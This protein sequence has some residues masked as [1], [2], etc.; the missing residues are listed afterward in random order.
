MALVASADM[1]DV[2]KRRAYYRA[3]YEQHREEVI[4]KVMSKLVTCTI[5]GKRMRQ[6]AM[7][8]HRNTKKH[9]MQEQILNLKS[10]IENAKR[11]LNKDHS[12][13]AEGI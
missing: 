13:Y 1:S 8:A 6:C 10:E 4:R 7:T 5:C 2:E 3:W 9:Q 12:K 11:Y